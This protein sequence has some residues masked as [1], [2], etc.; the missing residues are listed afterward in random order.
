M[1]T[2]IY[3]D[4][5]VATLDPAAETVVITSVAPLRDL[6]PGSVQSM[7]HALAAWTARCDAS[8]AQLDA[9][10]KRVTADAEKRARRE[11]Q[12]EKQI[13]S[14]MEAGEKG[15]GSAGQP[16]GGFGGPGGNVRGGFGGRGM[17]K[18]ESAEEDDDGEDLMDVDG[19][20]TMSAGGKKRSSGSGGSSGGAGG[21]GSGGFLSRYRRGSGR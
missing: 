20:A 10:I 4:L 7:I 12:A 17:G 5:L 18:R 2:A 1:T 6:A 3:N 14:A 9:E 15:A 19:S 21:G 16:R 11:A 8:L 13:K